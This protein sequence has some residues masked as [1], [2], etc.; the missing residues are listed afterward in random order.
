MTV[1]PVA[2][3]VLLS[4]KE[5]IIEAWIHEVRTS[6]ATTIHKVL[7]DRKIKANLG[8]LLDVIAESLRRDGPAMEYRLDDGANREARHLAELRE[9]QGFSIS[10]VLEDYSVLR[11]QIMS[12]FQRDLKVSTPEAFEVDARVDVVLDRALKTTVETFHSIET[13]D[14]QELAAT[15]ALTSLY[16]HG[17]F[18]QRL[19][20][21]LQRAK[22]YHHPLSMMML[23]IDHFKTY[24]DAYGHLYGDLALKEIA[25]ILRGDR[26]RSDV[27]ARYGGEEFGLILPETRIES[28]HLVAEKIRQTIEAHPFKRRGGAQTS[29]TVSIGCAG[30][31]ED[32]VTDA[33]QLVEKTD[34]ALYTAKGR[35]RNQVCS[36]RIRPVQEAV[37]AS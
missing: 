12:L 27:V 16:N 2:A 5:E 6:P 22:R 30:F 10:E 7:P 25:I 35:G 21:E 3:D 37:A 9:E 4:H 36:Y 19:D 8:F 34:R 31:D 32:Q 26:R 29:L 15:D 1:V 11:R 33:K 17:Y 20:Q 13:G 24:N 14:L 18:W 23:D 28:A